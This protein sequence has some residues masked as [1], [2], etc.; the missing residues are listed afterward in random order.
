MAGV[1]R[2]RAAH[3]E[4]LNAW[5]AGDVEALADLAAPN[6]HRVWPDGRVTDSLDGPAPVSPSVGCIDIRPVGGTSARAFVACHLLRWEAGASFDTGIWELDAD[7][8][9]HLVLHQSTL[10][11]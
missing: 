4:F 8:T 6:C 10:L 9:P 11:H 7:D 3:L 2:I 1:A 5:L